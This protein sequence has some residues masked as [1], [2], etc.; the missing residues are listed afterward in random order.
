MKRYQAL[1]AWI[2]C[3]FIWGLVACT[4]NS[5]FSFGE[6]TC[7][8]HQRKYC[9]GNHCDLDI[10][11]TSCSADGIKLPDNE[12]ELHLCKRDGAKTINW[13]L[14]PDGAFKFRDDGI[15]FVSLPNHDDFDPSTKKKGP[16]KY[17]WED[18]LKN[19]GGTSFKYA[20]RIQDGSGNQC[21]K[22]PRISND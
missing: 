14:S 3:A 1:A 21:D 6:T 13:K 8:K 4:G 9:Q 12:N 17:S 2:G 20:I 15:D 19:G 7:E 10:T 11:V 22:D 5:P 16:F 18:K